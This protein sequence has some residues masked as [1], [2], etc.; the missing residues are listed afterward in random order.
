MTL[1]V[2]THR[3]LLKMAEHGTTILGSDGS[4]RCLAYIK[5]TE[6]LAAACQEDFATNIDLRGE[7]VLPTMLV[8][9]GDRLTGRNTQEDLEGVHQSA[10]DE[11]TQ[12]RYICHSAR[13]QIVIHCFETLSS[14]VINIGKER[15][16][17]NHINSIQ[18]VDG[19][20]WILLHNGGTPDPSTIVQ[21]DP[22]THDV[23]QTVGLPLQGAHDLHID[24]DYV[25]VNASEQG[26]LMRVNIKTKE[27]DKLLV[28]GGHVKGMCRL[29]KDILIVGSSA[30]TKYHEDR[31]TCYADLVYVKVPEM[32]VVQ[33]NVLLVGNRSS[34]QIN[35][36]IQIN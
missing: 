17:V 5:A 2:A 29:N 14:D 11:E 4:Y 3:Y 8:F 23:L 9:K 12:S 20:L 25:Y 24:G 7:M 13:N 32:I 22:K 31:Q 33:R 18:V 27:V 28:L 36:I 1:Y 35:E 30:D 6:E 21:L 15:E 26:E 34:G 19:K 10:Y 16:D